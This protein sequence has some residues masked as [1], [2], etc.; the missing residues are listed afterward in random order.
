MLV[1]EAYGVLAARVLGL[2]PSAGRTRV[3]AVDGRA[4]SGKTTFA[5]RLAGAV[6]AGGASVE[7]LHTDDLASHED[8]FGWTPALTRGVLEP[9]GRGESGEHSVYDWRTRSAAKLVLVQP[10][11]VL[12]LE[13][14]GAGRRELASFLAYTIWLEVSVRAGL[15]RGLERDIA[16]NGD[17]MRHDLVRLWNDWVRAEA[18][19]ITDQRTW[20]RAKLLVDGNPTIAYDPEREYVRIA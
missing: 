18:S 6:K 8:F 3:V 14:V 7:G 19:F 15:T 17:E 9:L 20:E 1:V 13:G 12:I 2:P 11:D 10:A 5:K 4:G 16:E